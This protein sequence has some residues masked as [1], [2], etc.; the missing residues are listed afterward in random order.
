MSLDLNQLPQ[1]VPLRVA[2]PQLVAANHI[3]ALSSTELQTLIHKEV[4]ENPAIE[5]EEVEVCPH[6][7]RPLQGGVCPYCRG[8]A[9]QEPGAQSDDDFTDEAGMW[10]RQSS[11][12]D[13]E[14]DPT[15]RVAAQ[16]SLAEHL[17][18][19][20]QAQYTGRDAPIIEYLVGNLDEDGRLHCNIDDIVNLFDV[21][22][23]RVK[24]MIRSLQ[25]MEPVGVGARD[26]RECLLIQLH[27]LEAQGVHQ[28]FAREVI[29][30]FLPQLSEHKY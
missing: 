20:L 26:L 3:L 17:T 18:L 4:E 29:S 10:R 6:C 16:M 5:M 9:R 12:A 2:S 15:T 11:G 22:E 28:P 13:D 30:R 8:L 14:F 19:S 27:Y 1:Q 25:S 21:N 23:G 7:S 24:S